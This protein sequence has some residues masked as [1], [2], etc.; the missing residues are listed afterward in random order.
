ML[1]F[2]N[3]GSFPECFIDL[4]V[5][6]KYF[7]SGIYK[8]F[9]DK[10]MHLNRTLAR[11]IIIVLAFWL[12]GFVADYINAIYAKPPAWV[13]DGT[14][15][16]GLQNHS[17][18]EQAWENGLK[19][20]AVHFEIVRQSTSQP[21]GGQSAIK[22]DIIYY[23][24]NDHLGTPL[25]LTD[26]TGSIVWRREQT[27]FGETSFE[28]GATTENLRF[29]GQ[30]WDG[31]KQSS[32]NY[33]RDSYT[34]GL[35]RY[36]QADPIGQGGGINPFIYIDNNPSLSIDLYGLDWKDDQKR[37][38]R[39]AD[40]L[41]KGRLDIKASK[42]FVILDRDRMD[43]A[44]NEIGEGN[45]CEKRYNECMKK[46]LDKFNKCIKK[47]NPQDPPILTPRGPH[48]CPPGRGKK[49]E[50]VYKPGLPTELEK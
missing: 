33:Y 15:P 16:P 50:D 10:L 30:Y 19:R 24:H 1:L 5:N 31:E 34:P 41:A 13:T 21:Q 7:T 43:C 17:L 11:A 36:G 46:A 39:L 6:V 25:F 48:D 29:P 20:F 38:E 8:D 45:D 49:G 14:L 37:V 12:T 27:P 42:C 35:G 28:R 44:G 18:P 3:M 4:C 9:G 40:D 26:E 32:Y 2:L 47:Y 23:Y 22:D